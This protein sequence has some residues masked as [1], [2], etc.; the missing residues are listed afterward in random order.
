MWIRS[1]IAGVIAN[2]WGRRLALWTIANGRQ[3][4][5]WRRVRQNRKV[6]QFAQS[7]T[8]AL[9]GDRLLHLPSRRPAQMND[10]GSSHRAASRPRDY[11][12]PIGLLPGCDPLAIKV[13]AKLANRPSLN[14][15][16]PSLAVKHMTG[17]PNTALNLVCRLAMLGVRLRLV[18]VDTPIDADSTQFWGHVRVLT[19]FDAV[20]PN[21]ELIDASDR[22]RP[23]DIGES[24]LFLAT[25]WWTAQMVKYALRHT[26]HRQF[27][28]MIQDYEPLI[29][30]SSTSRALAE[31]TYRLDYIPIVNTSLLRDFFAR[32]RVGRFADPEFAARA[33]VFEPAV[34]TSR[35]YP[36]DAAVDRPRGRRRILFY[37]RPR[38]GLRNAFEMGVAAL[39]KLIVEGRIDP[40]EWEFLGMGEPFVPVGLGGGARLLSA[41]WLDLDSY[42]RQMRTSDILLSPMLSPHPSYPPLEMAAC[43][44]PVVTTT[45]GTKTAERLAA[46]SPNIIGVEPTI[47]ALAEGLYEAIGRDRLPAA[48]RAVGSPGSWSQSFAETVPAVYQAVLGLLGAPLVPSGSQI[49]NENRAGRLFPTYRHWPNNHYNTLRFDLLR[50]RR[51]AYGGAEAVPGLVSLVTPVWNTPAAMLA[52]LAETV[53][54]QD[55]GAECEWIILDN[56]SECSE[57]RDLLARLAVHPCTR[58]F[59]IE[60]N[61]GIVGGMRY[62]LEQASNRYIVPVDHDDLLAPD[63]IRVLT[64]ELSRAGYPALAYT[65]EDKLQ[66]EVF[67]DPYFKPDWDPVLFAHCCYTAHLGAMDRQLAVGLGVYS[68]ARANGSPDWDAFLR[69]FRAGHAPHHI[70]HILYTWRMHAGSTAADISVKD[71]VFS[72]HLAVLDRFLA[73]TANPGRYRVEA[74]PLFAGTPDWRFVR[75]GEMRSITTIVIGGTPNGKRATVPG[76]EASARVER[77]A[78][79]TGLDGLLRLAERCAETADYIH[80]LSDK[81]EIEDTSWPAEALAMFDLFPDVVLVGGRLHNRGVIVDADRYFG[82]GQGCDSPNRGR[83][84]TDPGY[85]AQVWKPHSASAIPTQH[86]VARA[87]FLV[88]ALRRLDASGLSSCNLAMWLGAAA[89]MAGGRVVYSP[90]FCARSKARPTEPTAIERDA[91]LA[92]YREL[93]PERSLLSP[94]LGLRPATAYQTMLP[95]QRHAE[96]EDLRVVS[97]AGYPEQAAADLIARRIRS[98]MPN[99]GCRFTLLTSVYE[100]TPAALFE[101]TAQSALAQ[102]YPFAE[103]VVVESGPILSDVS[104]IL[105]RL[106]SDPRIRRFRLPGNLGI[107]R[108]LRYCLERATSDFVIPLDHDDLLAPDALQQIALAI[109]A[110]PD[111]PFIFSDEDLLIDGALR[112]PFRRPGFD[113]ILNAVDSYIWHLCAFRRERGLELGV[114]TDAGAEFC[115]DWDTVCRFAAAG[116]EVLHLP[117]VLYHWRNHA[118]STSHSGEPNRGS[119]AS[120]KHV[121]AG[122]I[123]RQARPDLYEIGPCPLFRG[124]EQYAIRRRPIDPLPIAAITFG[125]AE[126]SCCPGVRER[127]QFAD[128]QSAGAAARLARLARGISAEHVMVQG[129]ALLPEEEHG[130]WEAMRLFEMHA[131]VAAAAGRIIAADGRV[132][133]CC[134]IPALD[135]GAITRRVGAYRNDPGP[136]AMAAKP[137]T[138]MQ[139]TGEYFFCR[140]QL[141]REASAQLADDDAPLN[142]LGEC[143]TSLIA[144]RGLRIVYSPLIEATLI[145]LTERSRRDRAPAASGYRRVPRALGAVARAGRRAT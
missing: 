104:G 43:G 100:R 52:D 22:D 45:Y 92:A 114:Y 96:E 87:D 132:V 64:A 77:I 48:N 109:E 74:S 127:Y 137:Q 1:P 94:W 85:F 26:R 78:E 125:H 56:G 75:T 41:P 4:A 99:A 24:D 16:L 67:R 51:A 13:S 98:P 49:E 128:W 84:M 65:D 111:A 129:E 122:V 72:S 3:T 70:P 82:F 105:D 142:R 88:N 30:P 63:C 54:G 136:F 19:G 112:S 116:D 33:I 44:R 59:R 17:G 107:I 71:Y 73:G 123:A 117:L 10:S 38:T 80:L 5:L 58:L 138:A 110:S 91:F 20:V 66:D 124:T 131:D 139:L 11:V 118:R 15:L 108:P 145:V 120:A 89:R 76:Q 23:F 47:E 69:F 9:A 6:R 18:S 42:A 102:S 37:A 101:E 32:E 50:E 31:E 40:T 28:Y 35:F 135:G 140:T 46:I 144:E 141:I 81:V 25:A 53:F 29:H 79:R 12:P 126:A 93:I 7:L 57:T 61:L 119:L 55:G 39:Q 27:F 115:H 133:L 95:A 34:D 14:V 143:L 113:P 121:M 103:W 2:P 21:V 8:T 62:C 60:S 97:G 106:E 86:C 90:F 36:E 68:D 130:C 83:A 134:A